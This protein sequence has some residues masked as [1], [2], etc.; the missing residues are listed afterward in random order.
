M[1]IIIYIGATAYPEKALDVSRLKAFIQELLRT[2]YCVFPFVIFV[3]EAHNEVDPGKNY[4]R[5]FIVP[6]SPDSMLS[7]MH[8]LVEGKIDAS[9]LPHVW[10]YGNKEQV[11]EEAFDRIPFGEHDCCVCL[12]ANQS[13]LPDWDGVVIYALTRPFPMLFIHPIGAEYVPLFQEPH[14]HYFCLF[15]SVGA[16]LEAE[17]DPLMQILISYFG[18]DVIVSNNVDV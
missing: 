5:N 16:L 1:A 6:N 2:Q 13:L 11:F 17:D 4:S 7:V 10:S 8:S 3:G 18:P 9:K 14:A 12:S 15:S